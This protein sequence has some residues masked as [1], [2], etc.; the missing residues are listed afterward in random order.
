MRKPRRGPRVLCGRKV[1]HS[2]LAEARR[3]ALRAQQRRGAP[4][5]HCYP[6]DAG[7]TLHWHL[8]SEPFEHFLT[9]CNTAQL[10]ELCRVYGRVI[11]DD[12]D[13]YARRR[14]RELAAEIAVTGAG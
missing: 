8:S 2:S 9:R 14:C 11:E 1:K 3:V 6:C 5:L 7:G 12:F 13:R 10:R 4:P